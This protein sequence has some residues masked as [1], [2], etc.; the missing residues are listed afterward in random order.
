M[1]KRR[2]WGFGSWQT[3]LLVNPSLGIKPEP[4]L[5]LSQNILITGFDDLALVDLARGARPIRQSRGQH[6]RLPTVSRQI[7]GQAH[8]PNQPDRVPRWKVVC[9]EQNSSHKLI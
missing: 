1:G 4:G 2:V 3:E 8:R 6:D 7:F 5:P 9:G